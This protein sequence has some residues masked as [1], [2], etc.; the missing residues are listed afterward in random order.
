[1][2]RPIRAA[3]M[4]LAACCWVQAPAHN[5]ID[6]N[7][8]PMK[9]TQETNKNTIRMFYSEMLNQRKT[10]LIRSIVSEDYKNEFGSGPEFF[11]R[12]VLQLLHSFPDVQ[13]KI[14]DIIAEGEKVI[15]YQHMLGTHKNAFQGIA[16][17]GKPVHVDGFA[18]YEFKNGKIV[19]HRVITDGR[20]FLEQLGQLPPALSAT[21][22]LQE[23]VHLIDRF[24]V[25]QNSIAEFKSQVKKNMGVVRIQ[26][27]YVRDQMFERTTENGS[28]EYIT[29]VEWKDGGSFENAKRAVQGEFQQMQFDP[30]LFFERLGIQIVRGTFKVSSR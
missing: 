18:S 23:S 21:S 14:G 20:T 29:I 8:L 26:P 5:Q 24:T 19:S 10:D 25:P 12:G 15:V 27:G 4:W 16:P 1:M 3:V 17:T 11:E 22:S 9:T 2:Q 28:L 7:K 13:W 30:Q 6:A